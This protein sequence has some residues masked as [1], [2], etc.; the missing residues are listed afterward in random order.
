MELT[1]ASLVNEALVRWRRALAAIAG[2]LVGRW[3]LT[4]RGPAISAGPML[5]GRQ[6]ISQNLQGYIISS[7]GERSASVIHAY[8]GFV[9]SLFHDADSLRVARHGGALVEA[10]PRVTGIG[11]ARALVLAIGVW[12]VER[13]IAGFAHDLLGHCRCGDHS[14]R[15]RCTKKPVDRHRIPP[16]EGSP[17]DNPGRAGLIPRSPV[18]QA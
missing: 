4:R 18:T 11:I 12:I 7:F 13:A 6:S 1:L 10:Q 17:R 16:C 9:R 15:S 5:A 14:Q 8:R 2:R 3:N